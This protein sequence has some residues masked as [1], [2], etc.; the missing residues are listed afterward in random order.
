MSAVKSSRD[1]L[2]L[3]NPDVEEGAK[4]T[5]RSRHHDTKQ[6]NR[7]NFAASVEGVKSTEICFL[8]LLLN[9]LA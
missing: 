7:R 8:S 9:V 3:A 2:E 5:R 1:V 6:T 4:A